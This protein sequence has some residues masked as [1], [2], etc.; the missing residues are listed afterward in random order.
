MSPLS[1]SLSSSLFSDM[2]LFLSNLIYISCSFII[3]VFAV[4]VLF[5]F[6]VFVV[7]IVFM[8]S[9]VPVPAL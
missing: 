9:C 1:L 8:F 7:S 3:V 5:L 4:F 2:K 6:F